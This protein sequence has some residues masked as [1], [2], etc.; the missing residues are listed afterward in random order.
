MR[1]T[2]RRCCR[3]SSRAG[4]RR[5]A[6]R[7]ARTSSS[8]W[9]KARAGRSAL[10]IAPTG[11]GKTLAGFLPTLVD[12]TNAVRKPR[13]ARIDRHGSAAL[14]GAAHALHLAAEGAGGRRRA[15]PRNAGARDGPA[16]P[17]RDA[18]RRHARLEAPAP[19]PRSAR[20]PAH[21]AGAA[22]AAAGHRRRAVSVRHVSGASCSTNCMRWSPPS[23]A[24]CCRSASRGCARSRRGLT[25]RR[26]VGDGRRARRAAPL[27][28]AAAGATAT[29]SP[30]SSSREAGAQPHVTM[31][32]T[33]EHLPWAGPFGAPRA[34]AKST[35]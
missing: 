11:A 17:H 20:H 2:P 34:R 19:A 32:D 33:D 14:R 28:G 15:Q 13:R 31:L 5:A 25:T 8:C 18:H 16:D 21:H 27:P 3:T 10:L 35:S 6:G 12:F 4:S 7:R 9:R 26:P 1:S 24:I 29:R 23:A 30:I 22:G